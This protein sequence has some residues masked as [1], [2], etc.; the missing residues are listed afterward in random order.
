M[1]IIQTQHA[2]Y[3]KRY[4]VSTYSLEINGLTI[5]STKQALTLDKERL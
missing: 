3:S 1:Y 2:K 5:F 4:T